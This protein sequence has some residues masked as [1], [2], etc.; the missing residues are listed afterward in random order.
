MSIKSIPAHS[1]YAATM[2]VLAVIQL[3]MGANLSLVLVLSIVSLCAVHPLSKRNIYVGDFIY[4]GFSLYCGSFALLIKTLL[5]QVVDSN[6]VTPDLSAF[7]LLVSFSSMTFA[8][9]LSQ[10]VR[11]GSE[12]PPSVLN[13][14]NATY[15]LSLFSKSGFAVGAILHILHLIFKPKF[16][17]GSAQADGFGGFGSFYFL[18][19]MALSAQIA[20]CKFGKSPARERVI[21]TLMFI[22][23]LVMSVAGNAKRD[24]IDAMLVVGLSA[25]AYR[26]KIG[27]RQVV[28][29]VFAVALVNFVLSPLIHITRSAGSSFTISERFEYT[30]DILSKNNFDLGRIN[31]INDR[32]A[33]GYQTSYRAFSNYVYPSTVSADRFALIMPL[34][35]VVRVGGGAR[36][37]LNELISQIGQTVLPGTIVEKRPGSLSD[38]IGWTYGF[39]LPGVVSRPVVGLPASSVATGGLLGAAI[40][41]LVLLYPVFIALNK[42]GGGLRN[43]PWAVGLTV[44]I[45]LIPER[46]V[47][48]IF[49]TMVREVPVIILLMVFLIEILRARER[50][51][52]VRQ[53]A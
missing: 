43:N 45:A 49:G 12:R 30:Y 13:H 46:T 42:V 16:I 22:A 36:I 53:R 31:A 9:W 35:Q 51:L 5:G 15:F 26:F 6:L 20:L 34:D 11:I 8:Y 1:M 44:S 47:E 7:F 17:N 3:G 38:I 40:I 2:L 23:I 19:L 4:I 48:A 18:L 25:Y 21:A 37:S 24:T 33:Q 29:G 14:F 32:V 10:L 39:R 41:P 27:L 50:V 52:S 28:A